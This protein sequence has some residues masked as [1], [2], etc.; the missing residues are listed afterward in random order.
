[1]ALPRRLHTA[2][3]RFGQDRRR[4]YRRRDGT[5]SIVIRSVNNLDSDQCPWI[6]PI[7]ISHLKKDGWTVISM[8]NDWKRIF[9]F[10]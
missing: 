10:E 1:L 8:K 7:Y 9:A 3:R 2:R 5:H 4:G 6:E